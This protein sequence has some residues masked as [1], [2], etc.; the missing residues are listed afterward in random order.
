MEQAEFRGL[1]KQAMAKAG[2]DTSFRT[3]FVE[4]PVGAVEREF[5]VSLPK[6]LDADSFRS[7]VRSRFGVDSADGELSDDALEAVAGGALCFVE[8]SCL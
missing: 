8:C 4:N 6:E 1:V 2:D 5:S 3:A 7:K